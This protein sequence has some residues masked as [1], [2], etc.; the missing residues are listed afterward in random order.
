MNN[1][2]GIQRS[3]CHCRSDINVYPPNKKF[4]DEINIENAMPLFYV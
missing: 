2:P 4:Y 1:I 3:R